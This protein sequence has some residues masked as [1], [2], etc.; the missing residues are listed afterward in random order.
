MGGEPIYRALWVMDV[1]STLPW[2]ELGIHWRILSREEMWPALC[3]QNDTGHNVRI[4]WWQQ[5]HTQAERSP[6]RVL[7]QL[8]W[9][10]K[11][12]DC[13]TRMIS[14]GRGKVGIFWRQRC[15][16]LPTGSDIGH[17]RKT[18][19]G[20]LQSSNV[21]PKQLWESGLLFTH[22]ERVWGE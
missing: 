21:C 22:M 16:D 17:I 8:R 18:N 15:Q 6:E 11:D 7:L 19:Q 13:W 14:E 9:E 12:A 2:N 10:M 4:D 20:G 3:A 1:L 5:G